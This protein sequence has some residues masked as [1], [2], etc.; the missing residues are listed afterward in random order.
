MYWNFG[1]ILSKRPPNLFLIYFLFFCF[2][3]FV[4]SVCCSNLALRIFFA[5]TL[6]V[7]LIY[8]DKPNVLK[9]INLSLKIE[10][11]KMKNLKKYQ[12]VWKIQ[13]PC[14][15]KLIQ[16]DGLK[17]TENISNLVHLVAFNKNFSVFIF[18][19]FWTQIHKNGFFVKLKLF[20][21]LNCIWRWKNYF[22]HILILPVEFS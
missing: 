21:Y 5:W 14:W 13:F 11:R 9:K 4:N 1:L 17:S 7:M 20:I 6:V 15:G 3:A 12:K 10:I 16:K 8:W 22:I 19:I 2:K 18:I